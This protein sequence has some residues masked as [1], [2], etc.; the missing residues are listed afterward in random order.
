MRPYQENMKGQRGTLRALAVICHS[1]IFLNIE[2]FFDRFI[3]PELA[4]PRAKLG[5]A[6]L[7]MQRIQE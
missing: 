3:A 6:K 2:H 1:H 5:L 7:D 4:Y